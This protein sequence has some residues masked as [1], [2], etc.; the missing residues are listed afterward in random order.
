MKLS[1]EQL[2]AMYEEMA[3]RLEELQ[4]CQR[5]TLALSSG[6]TFIDSGKSESWRTALMSCAVAS[7]D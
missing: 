3:D 6:V 5:S 7:L 2:V 4:V 1:K